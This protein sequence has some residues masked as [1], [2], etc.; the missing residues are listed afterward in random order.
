MDR[1]HRHGLGRFGSDS[2]PLGSSRCCELEAGQEVTISLS[3]H[4]EESE[5][6]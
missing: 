6:V 2:H 3:S 1:M 5:E 4:V